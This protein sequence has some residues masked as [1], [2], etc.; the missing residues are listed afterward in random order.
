MEALVGAP[1]LGSRLS[2][3]TGDDRGRAEAEQHLEN[4]VRTLAKVGIGARGTIGSDDP[5]EA[6]DD[7]LREFPAD[8]LIFATHPEAQANWLERDVVQVARA[9]YDVPVTHIVVDAS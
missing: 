9:R 1:A 2:H 7:A 5:I 8:E 6:V 3:W 4:T